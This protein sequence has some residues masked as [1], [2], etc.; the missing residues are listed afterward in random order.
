MVKLREQIKNEIK[1]EGVYFF[2]LWILAVLM[3]AGSAM[4]VYVTKV[5]SNKMPVHTNNLIDNDGYF[6]FQEPKD[7]NLFILTDFIPIPGCLMS[8]GDIF[9]SV[10]LAGTL[11]F[12][13]KKKHGTKTSTTNNSRRF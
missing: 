2:T 12:I 1:N 11:I 9:L 8:I 13:F 6:S 10:G 3:I 7:V 4:N 5:N